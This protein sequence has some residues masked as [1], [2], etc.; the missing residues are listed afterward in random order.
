MPW[1]LPA[2]PLENKLEDVCSI[3]Q[4]LD[5]YLLSPLW[6]FAADHLMLSR[7]SKGK[8]VGYHSLD[9]LHAKLQPLV[10]RR[11]KEDVL[12]D[13]PD[14]VVNNYYIDL[15][16]KQQRLHAGY[17]QSLMPLLNKKYLTPMDLR[18]IQELLLRMRQSCNSTYLIDRKTHISP[19]LAERVNIVDELALQ[20]KRKMVIFSE[21]TT[22]T[23]LIARQ[24]SESGMPFVELSGKIPV[25]KR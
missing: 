15:H 4:F 18:H 9:R 23:Y 5:P 8:I 13:L 12:K 20:N 19:K 21:W 24:L 25:K 16:E 2:P 22:M 7:Q 3:V 6:R 17:S 10:I 1:C 11:K 14:Q